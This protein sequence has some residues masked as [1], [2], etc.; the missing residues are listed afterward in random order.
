MTKD[1]KTLFCTSTKY[2]TVILALD[3]IYSLND[4]L[5]DKAFEK[6]LHTSLNLKGMLNPLLVCTEEVFKNSDIR[7]FERRPVQPEI[8]QGYRCLIGNNR[9]KFAVDNGYTHIEALIVE[10]FEEVKRLHRE[11][12]IEPRRM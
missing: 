1:H 7:K 5:Q 8:D 9:Y 2:N 11:T 6:K 4:N 10:S 3:E 12:E